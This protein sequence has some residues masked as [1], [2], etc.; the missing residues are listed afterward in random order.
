MKENI[1]NLEKIIFSNNINNNNNDNLSVSCNSTSLESNNNNNKISKSKNSTC[2]DLLIK[3]KISQIKQK[4]I[5]ENELIL[6]EDSESKKNIKNQSNK[7]IIIKNDSNIKNNNKNSNKNQNDK[8]NDISTTNNNNSISNQQSNS[9]KIDERISH[10]LNNSKIAPF[11]LSDFTLESTLGEGTYGTIFLSTH[12]ATKTKYAIKKIIAKD[13]FELEDFQKEFEILNNCQHEYILK[14]KSYTIQT[15]DETTFALYVLMEL[16]LCDWESEIKKKLS[17]RKFYTENELIIILKKL[18]N[19]LYF[20][21]TVKKIA[22]RDLKPQN[23][24][25][26]PNNI[27]KLSDFGEAKI[28]TNNNNNN[29]NNS[30]NKKQLNTLRGT[31]LYMAPVLYKGCKLDLDDVSHEPFK[32]DVYSLGVCFVYASTLNYKVLYEVRDCEKNED[33][34]NVLEKYLKNKYSEQFIFCVCAMLEVDE[35]KRMDFLMLKEF[36]EKR[37]GSIYDENVFN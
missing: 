1:K 23:I 33:I 25:I 24:L 13:I 4:N 21:Q 28:I 34:K 27:Y 14:V 30:G 10:I 7:N 20:L 22:H 36:V 12:K 2:S 32:S 19:A 15:L 6:K 26:F 17:I 11:S 31:E 16:A 9:L 5:N 3:D 18:L 29:N 37:F 8:N 35:S